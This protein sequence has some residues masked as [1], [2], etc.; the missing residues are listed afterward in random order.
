MDKIVLSEAAA[1]SGIALAQA[2]GA[3]VTAVHVMPQLGD[4][5]LDSWAQGDTRSRSRL[6]ALFEQ[7]SQRYLAAI[8]RQAAVAGVD[9][10]CV[11][12]SGGLP[13][14]AIL[15]TAADKGCDLIYMASH[16]RKGASALLLGSEAVKVLTHAPIP[17]LIH[18]ANGVMTEV[19]V[20]CR[21]DTAEEV[22][23]YEAGG[24]LQRFAQ[25]F[26]AGQTGSASEA[27]A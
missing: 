16:G 21:L 12:I 3:R 1:A 10:T 8:E 5:P 23:I 15:Q 19:S 4:A 14:E 7:Q 13:Y 9:C 18:R 24:V 27:A 25:D 17:V 11:T 22:S 26:L 2:L 20:T 6:R